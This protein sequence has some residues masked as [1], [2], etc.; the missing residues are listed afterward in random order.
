MAVVTPRAPP[1]AAEQGVSS[2]VFAPGKFAT[3]A[4]ARAM[5]ERAVAALKA[6]PVAALAKFNSGERSFRDRDI[7][8]FCYNMSNGNFTAHANQSLIGTDLK[9][10]KEKDG[11]PLGEKIFNATKAGTISTIDYRFPKPGTSKPAPKE[12]LVTRVGNQGCGVSYYK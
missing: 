7:Y 5:L 1:P 11:S 12:F 4:E 2:E 6:D 9:A 3:G 8:V 10:L